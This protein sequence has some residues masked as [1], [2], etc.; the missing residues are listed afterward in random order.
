MGEI[1]IKAY[2]EIR[3]RADRRI[4]VKENCGFYDVICE[5]LVAH[6]FKV[7]AKSKAIIEAVFSDYKSAMTAALQAALSDIAK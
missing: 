4:M 3:Y 1:K 2:F 5:D 7:T 6:R